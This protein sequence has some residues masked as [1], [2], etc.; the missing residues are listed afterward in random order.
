[1]R[2]V[3]TV[4][5]F[6]VPLYAYSGLISLKAVVLRAWPNPERI[7]SDGQNG[8]GRIVRAEQSNSGGERSDVNEDDSD[9]RRSYF[10]RIFRG[11]F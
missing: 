6:I 4:S 1:M 11:V 5:G 10:T 7:V 9:S 2:H 8:C 3:P